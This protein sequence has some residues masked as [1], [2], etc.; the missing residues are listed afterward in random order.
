MPHSGYFGNNINLTT[1]TALEIPDS[2]VRRYIKGSK[3][4]FAAWVFY[5]L[6]VW[7]LKGVLLLIYKKLTLVPFDDEYPNIRSLTRCVGW[8]FGNTRWRRS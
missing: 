1:E 6:G 5:I 7:T 4:A 3:H 8:D 2:E